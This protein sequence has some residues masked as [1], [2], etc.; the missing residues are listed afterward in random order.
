MKKLRR[1]VG[2]C[3]LFMVMT[4]VAVGLIY[5]YGGMKNQNSISEGTLIARVGT[6]WNKL[7]G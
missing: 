6:K 2:V 3:L 1:R 7:F 4:A 5:Y